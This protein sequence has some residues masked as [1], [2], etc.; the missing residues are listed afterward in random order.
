MIKQVERYLKH[1]VR[2]PN[3][4][5]FHIGILIIIFIQYVCQS[6]NLGIKSM[7][8]HAS[9]KA[10]SILVLLI[11]LMKVMIEDTTMISRYKTTILVQCLK[12]ISSL[13]RGPHIKNIQ[14]ALHHG[15]HRA[16][17]SILLIDDSL[18]SII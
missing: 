8:G 1:K 7:F 13:I 16:L 10:E 12:T 18:F 14:R 3:Y 9:D 6:L 2:D 11:K 17:L 4:S 5:S 15:Y